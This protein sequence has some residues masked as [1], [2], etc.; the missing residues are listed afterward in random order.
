MEK[1]LTLHHDTPELW[2]LENYRA[3]G[4]YDGLEKALKDME[5][6][7]IIGMV[8]DAGL[9]GRG[10]AGFPSG[11]KWGFLPKDDRP[12]YLICNADESEPGTF[13]DRVLLEQDPHHIIEG[14]V[15]TCFAVKANLAFVYM[16]G[17]FFLGAKRMQAAIDE[18][19]EAGYLG[20]N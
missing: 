7:E 16:R 17:E 18:A 2:K 9:R 20:K 5:P 8:R 6:D 14:I 12:R 19:Y 3:K 1:V 11:V 10:G 15:I 4:G 13:K